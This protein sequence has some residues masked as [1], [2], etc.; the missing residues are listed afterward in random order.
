M[1][2]MNG[3]DVEI[4]NGEITEDERISLAR[5]VDSLRLTTTSSEKETQKVLH[6][7]T[8]GLCAGLLSAL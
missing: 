2:A 7:S 5:R 1:A 3:E 6:H 4:S 8:E